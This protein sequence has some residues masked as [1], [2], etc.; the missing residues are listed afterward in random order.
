M[1]NI[2]SIVPSSAIPSYRDRFK[3]GVQ[4]HVYWLGQAGFVLDSP[5]ARVVIDPYLSNSLA[6][7]YRGKRFPHHR[8]MPPPIKP[9]E[10]KDVDWVLS[11]HIHTDHLDP[12]TLPV[13]AQVNP[14]CRFLVPRSAAATAL[15]RGVPGERMTVCNSGEPIELTPREG[16]EPMEVFVTPAAHEKREYDTE[17]ND[18]YLG[19][20]IA[21]NGST[22]YH[23]GDTIPFS[24][25]DE[26]ISRFNIDLALL[27]VNG[28]DE[29]RRSNRVPG[30]L[31]L[32][33]AVDLAIRRQIPAFIG[34]HFD[35]F[36]FNTIERGW[37]KQRI[38]NRV[39]PDYLESYLLANIGVR[40]ELLRR[41]ANGYHSEHE[42]S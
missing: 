22:V 17:G 24:D 14:Q 34:H 26:T 42:T 31:T 33:E 21:A 27:P 7:K 29:L 37:G 39:P 6:E 28:R 40:Y 3:D 1:S 4:F 23:S 25:L 5:T 15:E 19:Y 32:D 20:A 9:E 13:L 41:P 12:G 35:M 36:G 18:L 10:L 16:G 11:T 30:N 8:M 2:L 38:A